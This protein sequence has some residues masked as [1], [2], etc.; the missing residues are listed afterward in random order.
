MIG[1]PSPKDYKGAVQHGMLGKIKIDSKDISNMITIFGKNLGTIQGKTT[2][3][4]PSSV[5]FDYIDIPADF[6]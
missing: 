2:N 1:F 6:L 4:A 3:R 5:R